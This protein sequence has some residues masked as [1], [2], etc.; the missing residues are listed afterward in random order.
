MVAI[1]NDDLAEFFDPYEK[2]RGKPLARENLFS[3]LLHVRI[4]DSQ[5]R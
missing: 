3:I 4:A 2:E 1:G 5:Q